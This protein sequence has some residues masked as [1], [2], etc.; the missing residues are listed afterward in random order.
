MQDATPLRII[1]APDDLCEGLFGQVLLHVFEV[2]PYLDGLGQRPEQAVIPNI[3][4]L[5][6]TPRTP[7]RDVH[8]LSMHRR[9]GVQLGNDWQALHELWCKHFI[10]SDKIVREADKIGTLSNT[11]GVHYRGTD[12]QL[13]PVDTNAVSH[14][15]Y[16]VMILDCLS[17]RPDIQQV[18]LATDDPLFRDFL[19]KRISLPV[20]HL[21]TPDFHK[22]TNAA[23]DPTLKTKQAFL[24][25]LILSR[26]AVVLKT[27][28]A[29][30][31]FA[32]VLNPAL[33]IYRCS[34]S[35]MFSD[36]PYFP[37]AY[38]PIYP[39]RSEKA[40]HIMKRL[41]AHDWLEKH[42]YPTKPFA[43]VPRVRPGFTTRLV[44]WVQR[45]CLGNRGQP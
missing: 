4:R 42:R 29:L 25:C 14:E 32:K 5:S 31:G 45:K 10:L 44:R 23:G 28:S 19:Q 9:H 36:I 11:L 30:S 20:L 16:L 13:N 33:E 43:F 40:I 41:M 27:C 1:S 12:K 8:L 35:K 15:D 6:Y 3:L 24:D 21:G 7:A 18:F 17:H 22:S 26:C 2:L 39:A 34:A 37:V 38:I